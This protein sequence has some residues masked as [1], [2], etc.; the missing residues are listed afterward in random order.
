MRAIVAA[1]VLLGAARAVADAPD[2]DAQAFA[3]AIALE[4]RGKIGEAVAALEAFAAARP[5][6]PLA[7]DALAEAAALCEARLFDPARALGL[8]KRLLDRYP[9]SRGATRAAARR[10][11]LEPAVAAGGADLATFERLLGE[12]GSPPRP[13]A[14]AQVAR[15]LAEHPTFPFA[16]R[17]LFWLGQ[18]AELAGQDDEALARYA[19]AAG[20][21]GPFESR[22]QRARAER[23]LQLARL[24]EA[25]AAYEALAHLSDPVAQVALRE[26]RVAVA[27]AVR[28]ARIARVAGIWAALAALAA[29]A[30]G[31]RRLWPV[32]TEVR[33]FL[34]VAAIFVAAAL[35]TR[36]PALRATAIIAAGASALIWLHAATRRELDARRVAPA[37]Q[38][39]V[40]LAAASALGAVAVLAVR[41]TGLTELALETLRA[42]PDR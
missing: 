11:E 16:D 28:R 21:R 13:E 38:L 34:P 12:A 27:M 40:A 31:R 14:R 3:A 36:G 9:H 29:L 5:A 39:V 1:L 25:G 4:G 2:P 22:A 32:P 23:L 8:W 19:E 18:A 26:G 15:F 33:F 20:R 10:D 42:G 24:D 17:G 30:I 37:L 41:W 35:R 6:H 7:A